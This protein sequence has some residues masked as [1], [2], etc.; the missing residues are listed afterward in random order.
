MKP[1]MRTI[2][3][4]LAVS[5][6]PALAQVGEPFTA[7]QTYKDCTQLSTQDPAASLIKA[8]AWLKNDDT[9]APHHCRAMALYGL[10]QYKDA[11]AELDAVRT[12]IDPSQIKLRSYV[13]QQAA[14]AWVEAGN[15]EN[16]IRVLTE[17]VNELTMTQ[18]DNLTQ[19]KL[20]TDMLLDRSRIRV[21]YGQLAQ[22]VQ[23][24]DQAISLSPGNEQVL[25]QR[26]KIFAQLGD[27]ALAQQDLQVVLRMNPK[28]AEAI[29][30]MRVLRDMKPK[31]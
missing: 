28:Q 25:L 18:G 2:F 9:V 23:D 22:G 6:S 30:L 3:L 13:T 5:A 1:L 29:G 31:P 16:A 24:L 8:D 21:N 26:A 7:S 15:A 27:T 11:G 14:R 12:K 17:Q 19:S 20:A 10:K 4:L